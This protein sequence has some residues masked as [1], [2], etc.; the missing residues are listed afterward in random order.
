MESTKR[1]QKAGKDIY[2]KENNFCI[3]RPSNLGG[4]EGDNFYVGSED[5]LYL[6]IFLPKTNFRENNLPVMFW[7]HGGGNTSG[8]KDLYDFS[9]MVSKHD[10]IV[11]RINYRLGPFGWFT[12]PVNSRIF[13]MEKIKH[14]ILETLDIIMALKWVKNNI[15]SFGGDANNVTIFGESAGGHNVLSLLV[16]KKSQRTFS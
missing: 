16:I 13:K 1:N 5:C 9:K 11:V 8:L 6:D 15:N 7:I 12:H 4:V 14:L 3:Q 2:P 10:V